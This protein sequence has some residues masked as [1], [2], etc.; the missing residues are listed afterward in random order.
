MEKQSIRIA[1]RGA[2]KSSITKIYHFCEKEDLE[3]TSI[4]L[5]Q[6]KLSHLINAFTEFKELNI[7]ISALG[8]ETEASRRDSISTFQ[9]YEEKYLVAMALLQGSINRKQEPGS[10]SPPPDRSSSVC[11]KLPKIE[12]KKFDGKDGEYYPFI[13]LFQ[14]LI[15]N[16][17][18]LSNLQRLYY[19]RMYLGGEPHDLIKNL[20]LEDVNYD[21]ALKILSDRYDN[22]NKVIT[23]HVNCILDI[24]P[25]TKCTS[26]SLRSFL[27]QVKQSLSALVSLKQPVH[28]WDALLVPMLTRKVDQYTVRAYYLEQENFKDEPHSLR[29]FLTFLEKKAVALEAT[30]PP[31]K[32]TSGVSGSGA[33]RSYQRAVLLTSQETCEFCHSSP[34]KIHKCPKFK[35]ASIK[36]RLQF[37]EDSKRCKLC[38][39]KHTNKC[40]FKFKCL[41]CKGGHNSLLHDEVADSAPNKEESPQVSLCNSNINN[42]HVLLPTVS[43]KLYTK[44]GGTLPV[45][46]VLDSGSEVSMITKEIADRIDCTL[47]AKS[48]MVVGVC[49]GSNKINAVAEFDIHASST[50]FSLPISCSVVEKITCTL[51]HQLIDV[52]HLNIPSHVQLADPD[53][54]APA[55]IHILLAADVF[56]QVLLRE[57]IPL[58][59]NGP[60]LI[61]TKLGYVVGGAVTE[62]RHQVPATN[63]YFC[64]FTRTES[65]VS[66][67]IFIPPC[68]CKNNLDV[69]LQNL[70][71]CEKVDKIFLESS[72][73]KDQAEIIFSENVKLEGNKF[74]VSLP[75]KLPLKEVN[76]GNS[77]DSALQRFQNLEKRF[78]KNKILFEKYK[79]FIDEYL[80]LGHAKLVDISQ[81]D[82]ENDAVYFLPHHPVFNEGSKTTKLRVVFD[83]GMLTKNKISL[84]D[85]L[86]NGPTVQNELFDILILFRLDKYILICDIKQMFRNIIMDP[87]HR[88]LQNIL[89]RESPDKPI[90]C[91]QL[92]TVTY[93]MKCSSYLATRCL[94]ELAKRFGDKYPKA[95]SALKYNCYVDDVST[96]SNQINDLIQLKNELIQLMELGGFQLHKWCSNS[97][98]VLKDI[99]IEKQQFHNIEF[100]H[101]DDSFAKTLGLHYNVQSDT[102]NISC[103][104]KTLNEIYTKREVLSFVSKFFDPLGLVGPILVTAK[105]FLQ[106][107]WK[108]SIG[109]DSPLPGDLNE[110]WRSF[111][112]G[113]INMPTISIH[114]NIDISEYN[115]IELIGFADASSRAYGC[116][117]YLRVV[118]SDGS[119]LVDLV[120]SKSRLNPVS[121]QLTTPRLELNSALLLAKLANRLYHTLSIKIDPKNIDV[122][123]YLDSQIVLSWLKIDPLR[124]NAYVAN[125][126]KVIVENTQSFNWHYVNTSFNPADCLSRGVEPCSLSENSLWWNGPQFMLQCDYDHC[127]FD[128]KMCIDKYVDIPEI[129]KVSMPCTQLEQDLYK[130]SSLAKTQRVIAFILR[131]YNNCKKSQGQR[132]H[133]SYV[134]SLTCKELGNAM[135]VI[136]KCDQNR[137]YGEEIKCIS[138]NKPIKGSLLPLNPFIDGD[139]LLR[140]GGRLQKANIPY[141][142][143]YPAILAQRSH[144]TQLVIRDAHI[145][146]LH[147]GPK[148]I[149][150]YLNQKYWLIN[151]TREIKHVTHKC[152]VC[153]RLKANQASQLMGSLPERRVTAARPFEVVGID[154]GGPFQI[155]QSRVRRVLISKGYVLLFVCFATKAIHVELASDLTTDTFLACLKRFIAR[156]NIPS[157]ISCDNAATFRGANNQ[158]KRLYELSQCK[159]HNSMVQDFASSLGINFQF[160]PSYSPH[161]AGIWEAGIKSVKH[162]LKR[163]IGEKCLTFE[164]LYTVLVQVEGIVNSRPLTPKILLDINDM[165]YLTPGHFLTGA[166]LCSFPEPDV[167]NVPTNRLKFW[168]Q[169][170]QIQQS[171]WRQWH[172][173]Y[174]V[175]LQSRP[176]WRTATPN[177]QVGTMV[178]V[179][180]NNVSPLS[181]PIARIVAVHPGDDG[182]V[183]A[184]DIKTTNGFVMKTS[185]AKVC[186]LPIDN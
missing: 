82:L 79:Q 169:C 179:K 100:S 39:N 141:A 24:N 121:S 52:S 117:L 150:S 60:Y 5:L 104:E 165:N 33:A 34:H 1:A 37:I 66:D 168:D 111:A 144:I 149:L 101:H 163:A 51:P 94:I 173:Q 135:K 126:V 43:V 133:E 180:D 139:G 145:R 80:Q 4:E 153:F 62:E 98:E 95:A 93:G 120:C 161:W 16:D 99:P 64:N 59:L 86:M 156:R 115:K 3:N 129:K 20:T 56:F 89:W 154:Y 91:L 25:I 138:N 19:L 68:T 123:L 65:Q 90:Q 110:K 131:F 148:L 164:E 174:L 36:Q 69:H 183:R 76:L 96:G 71:E 11:A 106:D 171:F 63:K 45:R 10:R 151:G 35:T 170:T 92:Q 119:A 75:I 83:G 84:N 30:E 162:H 167:I 9:E 6:V 142:Q 185:I 49:E 178:I 103:P 176:K 13:N 88:P 87:I 21:Q 158:L 26:E 159:N 57:R 146:L 107:L 186:V 147:A 44:D 127:S 41:K 61:N 157:T 181:W 134:P 136:I 140:V 85:L 77:L 55:T 8:D 27:A 32:R 113:L 29:G 67:D 166:P 108:A 116:C 81:Y 125:R 74:Q 58:A 112:S 130:F 160:V 46:A 109:W 14:S 175:N 18:S 12:I 184:I 143:K 78:S 177:L 50:S 31:E 17:K 70:W 152:I 114:R 54:H 132:K 7:Q 28:H 53:F 22:V 15:H 97:P 2:A 73:E 102:I 47:L 42:K 72:S 172:R 122:H 38:L 40:F 155:K 128:T 137:C 118:K 124:L 23:Q 182:K 48:H 105:L